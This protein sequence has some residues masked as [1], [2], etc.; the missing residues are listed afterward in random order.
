MTIRRLSVQLANQIAAGEVVERPASVVKEL[1]ENAV[2]AGG[3][4]IILEIK[5][6]GRQLIRVRDDGVGIP[7]DELALALAPHATSKISTFDDLNAI[8]TLGFRGEALASIASVSKLTLTSKVRESENAYSVYVEGPEQISKIFPAAHL[9]G[10]SVEVSELFFN[11]PARRRFLK[12][13]RSEM[14]KIRDVF[15][16]CALA[17]PHLGFELISEGK[18]LCKVNAATDESSKMRRL[19]KL[20]GPEF[21]REGIVIKGE[22]PSLEIE[23]IL[24]PAPPA[25]AQVQELVYIFLNGRAV[26]DRML[27]HALKEGFF[28]SYHRN[29]PVRA[30]VYLRCDPYEVDVNVHPRKDEVRFHNTAQ[31]HDIVVQTIINSLSRYLDNALS[32]ESLDFREINPPENLPAFPSGVSS[33]P[34]RPNNTYD[35]SLALK[36]IKKN[37]TASSVQENFFKNAQESVNKREQDTYVSI[38]RVHTLSDIDISA[39]RKNSIF[40]ILD[41]PVCGASL[42]RF[43]NRF[44][45]VKTDSLLIKVRILEYTQEVLKDNVKLSPML[46]PFAVKLGPLQ[47]KALKDARENASRCGFNIDLSRNTVSLQSIPEVIRGCDLANLAPNALTII[48]AAKDDLSRGICPMQLADLIAK[49]SFPIVLTQNKIQELLDRLNSLDDLLSLGED[50]QEVPIK[51]L[52]KEFLGRA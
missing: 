36:P 29:V 12:S 25:F 44:F 34:I 17:N 26:A 6:A 45:F 32:E 31:V 39:V 38:D 4:K 43:D 21:E 27:S 20:L 46:V 19:S 42:V 48:A 37:L 33:T 7:K 1:L 2:D 13:D 40:T 18:S 16:R 23:G 9:D 28:E 11:T 47:L 8:T 41:E 15:T 10:T 3:K 5:G 52:A 49:A 14:L 50:C 51:R 35:S 22:H 30:V 24:L